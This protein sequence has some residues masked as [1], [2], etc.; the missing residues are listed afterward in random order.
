MLLELQVKLVGMRGGSEIKL[1]SRGVL[2]VVTES[3]REGKSDVRPDRGGPC[4]QKGGL[5]ARTWRS[6]FMEDEEQYE[7]R[8]S[9]LDITLQNALDMRYRNFLGHSP[10]GLGKPYCSGS[11][12]L[13]CEL[14]TLTA[15]L[16]NLNSLRLVL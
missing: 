13:I 1:R 8:S 16:F 2:I 11:G 5:G 15:P 14:P 6:E 12:Q 7:L 9:N 4:R 3:R 10:I